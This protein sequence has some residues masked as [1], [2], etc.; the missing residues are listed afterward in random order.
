MKIRKIFLIIACAFV[1]LGFANSNVVR[2]SEGVPTIN[3]DIVHVTS[4]S[5]PTP[6]ETIQS[7]LTA[8]DEYDG[9]L[10]DSIYIVSD[11]Y[12]PNKH[13]LGTYEVTF[14]VSDSSN[15]ETT[16]VV[17]VVVIDNIRPE[18]SFPKLN[19]IEVNERIRLRGFFNSVS[20]V[21]VNKSDE[22]TWEEVDAY[23]RSIMIISDNYDPV[24]DLV[25][26]VEHSFT[27]EYT[28][29]NGNGGD[30]KYIVTDTSGNKREYQLLQI[31]VDDIPPVID[32]IDKYTKTYKDEI[33]DMNYIRS[34]LTLTDDNP[35]Q[36][37]GM[38]P[39]PQNM[40]LFIDSDN[41]SE[42]FNIVGTH[43][44]VF[45]ANDLRNEVF[46]T[47]VIEVLDLDF[48]VFSYGEYFITVSE[49][50]ELSHQDLIDLLTSMG[51]LS[52]GQNLSFSLDTYSSNK[53]APGSYV[54]S[55]N[56]GSET[57]SLTINVVGEGLNE[58]I[59][60]EEEIEE[61]IETENIG[62]FKRIGNFFTKAFNSVK[63]LFVNI[64]NFFAVMFSFVSWM[65]NRSSL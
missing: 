4:V 5:S 28:N 38:D 42:N 59:I 50:V 30:I 19:E 63:T 36:W 62:I 25:V 35:Y 56:A 53:N 55:L 54:M 21:D 13:I 57:L 65:F 18:I 12:T 39:D 60:E 29:R 58:E 9:D 40:I 22:V 31:L 47:V 32:G 7:N 45:R 44:I 3:G 10:T 2:A 34:N 6:V 14:G 33:L 49:F 16:L 17:S 23:L 15:N 24:E 1:S 61:E 48:P 51:A 20:Y 64:S 27:M 37:T 43:E 11:Y 26:T 52:G 41:Y 46:F 8:Y